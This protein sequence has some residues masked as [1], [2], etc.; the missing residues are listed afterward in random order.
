MKT[1]FRLL[2]ALIIAAAFTDYNGLRPEFFSNLITTW[3]IYA[4]IGVSLV[5]GW[6]G[7]PLLARHF[8]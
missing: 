5:I 8:D 3:G 7:M 4:H 6:L 2:L 1:F